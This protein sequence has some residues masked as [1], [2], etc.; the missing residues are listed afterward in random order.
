PLR[1]R[2]TH[3]GGGAFEAIRLSERSQLC[4]ECLAASH[5]A[6]AA[7]LEALLELPP[8]GLVA[9]GQ[10]FGNASID[11]ADGAPLAFERSRC[12]FHH[13]P[14]RGRPVGVAIQRLEL[15]DQRLFAL[16]IG[17]AS[18]A[19]LREMSGAWGISSRACAIEAL[20]QRLRSSSRSAIELLPF[21]AQ[22]PD[23]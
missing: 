23:P 2:V 4:D 21:V 17:C 6:R 1:L 3:T 16:Q 18:I 5:L 15:F 8:R 9:L 13:A 22:R 20:P 10:A 7:R 19:L 11:G 14:V 12:S